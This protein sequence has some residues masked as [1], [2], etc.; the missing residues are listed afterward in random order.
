MRAPMAV[1][2]AEIEGRSRTGRNSPVGINV[3]STGVNLSAA[4]MSMLLRIVA[5]ARPD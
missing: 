1:G 5:G 2:I 3:L 4:I